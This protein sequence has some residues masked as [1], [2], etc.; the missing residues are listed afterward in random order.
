MGSFKPGEMKIWLMIAAGALL[1]MW[2]TGSTVAAFFGALDAFPG[3]DE[4]IPV[5]GFVPYALPLD[6]ET[7]A[8][9]DYGEG[10]TL[11]QINPMLDHET[12]AALQAHS[13]LPQTPAEAP[14]RLVIDSIGLNEPV[15][16]AHMRM[17]WVGGQQYEQWT[18]PDEKAVGWHTRSARLG[19]IGNT[20]LNGHHNAYGEVFRQLEDVQLGDV[21]MVSGRN[22]VYRYV[23]VN[24]MILPE[25]KLG[26]EDRLDNA[27]WISPSEDERLTLV[28]CHPYESNTHRLI[29]VARRL[30]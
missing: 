21:V 10:V 6:A 2:G 19:E 5:E 23:V 8:S 26:A 20:V 3:G 14:I 1:L 9:G 29:L 27:R 28:T 22:Q 30:N 25:R 18:A 11:R 17:V 15:A 12:L 4:D 13:E 24:R 7:L 16:D